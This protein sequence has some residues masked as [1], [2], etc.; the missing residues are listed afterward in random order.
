[1]LFGPDNLGDVAISSFL[2][3]HSCHDCCRRLGLAGQKGT[4]CMYVCERKGER[5]IVNVNIANFVV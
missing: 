2:Q 3:K 5:E 4:S 1:M